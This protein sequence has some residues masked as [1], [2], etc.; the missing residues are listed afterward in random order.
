MLESRTYRTA[1][2]LLNNK[3]LKQELELVIMTREIQFTF[4]QN[5]RNLERYE[6][7]VVWLKADDGKYYK[8]Q[9]QNDRSDI[10]EWRTIKQF[11]LLEV[12]SLDI[13]EVGSWKGVND[14]DENIIAMYNYYR[15]KGKGRHLVKLSLEGNAVHLGNYGYVE[16]SKRTIGINTWSMT[17]K[18]KDGRKMNV[19]DIEKMA[20]ERNLK[21]RYLSTFVL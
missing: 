10:L 17:E 4:A 21:K 20:D 5:G 15:P 19:A 7:I 14:Y 11:V 6:I 2:A 12:D 18:N 16:M 8:I 9:F 13:R 3:I 1:K